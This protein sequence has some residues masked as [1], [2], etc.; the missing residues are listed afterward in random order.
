VYA[1]SKHAVEGYSESLDHETREFGVRTPKPRY[2][3]GPLARQFSALKKVAP[4]T[5]LDK[6]I[7]KANNLTW[8]PRPNQVPQNVR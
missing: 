4:T 3:A 8:A 7:R 2:P 5:L 6:G 1:A